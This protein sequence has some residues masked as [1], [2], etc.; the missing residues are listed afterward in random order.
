MKC[1]EYQKPAIPINDFAIEKGRA[2][3]KTAQANFLSSIIKALNHYAD[4]T[5]GSGSVFILTK[6]KTFQSKNNNDEL[7]V[8]ETC[9]LLFR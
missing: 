9:D 4:L 8:D 3:N 6:V 2:A 7:D 5:L 1:L